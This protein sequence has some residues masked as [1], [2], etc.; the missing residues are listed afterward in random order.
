MLITKVGG[1]TGMSAGGS[2]KSVAAA[3]V[4]AWPWIVVVLLGLVLAG[5]AGVTRPA[6]AV[7]AAVAESKP[8]V[9][10]LEVYRTRL[11]SVKATVAGQMGTFLLDTGGGVTVITPGFAKRI[12]CEPWGSLSGFTMM[13]VRLDVQRCN[14]TAFEIAGRTFRA[15]TVGVFDYMSMFPKDAEPLD[16]AIGLDVFAG[17]AVTLEVAGNRF[18]VETP[19]SLA[20]RTATMRE[21]PAM[22]QREMHGVALSVF[23]QVP[24]PKGPAWFEMDSGNGGTLLMARHIAPLFGLNP[25]QDRPPQPA[26]F[27]LAGS[28]P[29]A[30]DFFVPDMIIDGNLGMPFLSK[31]VMTMDLVRG[32]LWF[33]PAAPAP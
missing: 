1:G 28:V 11:R 3:L 31:Q 4:E 27:E 26:K 25:K 15:P 16:G 32:R 24:T 29:V 19:E 33:G 20:A 18:T 2:R 7:K 23:A 12:G 30:G 10:P 13:A 8:L 17:Q 22:L 6:E 21:V 5:C 14:E 9:I